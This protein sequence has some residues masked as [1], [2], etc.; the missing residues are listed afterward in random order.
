MLTID[1]TSVGDWPAFWESGLQRPDSKM[2][3]HGNSS[4]SPI[5]FHGSIIG[6]GYPDIV[7]LPLKGLFM[8]Q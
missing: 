4:E 2:I 6:K 7:F 8:T 1:Y 5:L 3:L